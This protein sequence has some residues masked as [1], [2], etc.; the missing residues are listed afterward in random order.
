MI[1]TT[2]ITFAATTIDVTLTNSP[3]QQQQQQPVQQ[4]NTPSQQ[5]HH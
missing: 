2:T 4:Q 1:E 3:L 5:Q